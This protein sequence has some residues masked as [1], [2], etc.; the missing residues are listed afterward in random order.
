MA[1][2]YCKVIKDNDNKYYANMEVEGKT[3]DLPIGVN[4]KKLKEEIKNKTG[5]DILKCKDMIFEKISC[6]EKIATIDCTRYRN[7][8]DCRIR[9]E[10]LITGWKPS[11]E[12]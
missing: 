7:N 6:N 3:I 11:W 2:W 12:K 1:R 8:G 9:I 10:E 5:I 4:Y